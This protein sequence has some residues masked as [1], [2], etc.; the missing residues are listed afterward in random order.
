MSRASVIAMLVAAEVLVAGMALYAVG[1]G[2]APIG[3]SMH[4]VA[5]VAAT[6]API[7]AGAAPH[8]VIDDMESRVRVDTSS[9][10][11]VHVRD[12]TQVH[13]GLFSSDRYAQLVVTRIPG[14]VRIQRPRVPNASI[15]IFGFRTQRIE[16][17]VPA[18]AQLEITGCSG[19]DVRGISGGVSVHSVDGHVTLTDL[20]G[21]VYART[22]D[23]YLNATNVRGDRLAME[24]M[25]GHLALQDVAVVALAA[26]TRDGRIETQ[27]LSV[28]GSA[29]LQTEDGSV[30][31]GLAR[32][33]DVTIN[34]SARDGR[35]S[36]DGNSV[37]SDDDSAQRTIRLRSG[38]GQMKVATAD[39]SIRIFT[40]G[41]TQIQ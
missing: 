6:I 19:A 3:S 1:R 12:L 9:D 7:A 41:D 28:S 25:D 40:H 10:D 14:G 31:L 8:V 4:R 32:D 33:A 24:S 38:T 11:R 34:A 29:T 15:N 27:E 23:G 16:V 26:T 2:H 5:F 17:D 22:D 18:G 21:S 37:E 30:R 35:I 36:V 39:G 20:Q 13:G